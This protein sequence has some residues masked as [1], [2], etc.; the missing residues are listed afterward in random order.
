MVDIYKPKYTYILHTLH[1]II[2][3]KLFEPHEKNVEE[4]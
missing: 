4:S 1:T 3:N 2:T